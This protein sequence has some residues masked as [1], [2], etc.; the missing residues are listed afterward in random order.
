M[1]KEKLEELK[2]R[3]KE[4]DLVE[5]L[6]KENK[7]DGKVKEIAINLSVLAVVEGSLQVEDSVL[8]EFWIRDLKSRGAV[9]D[10]LAFLKNQRAG[11]LEELKKQS[12]TEEESKKDTAQ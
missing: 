5:K 2:A 3:E 6:A 11:L 7:M 10:V 1:D 8:M 12:K 9:K 4:T